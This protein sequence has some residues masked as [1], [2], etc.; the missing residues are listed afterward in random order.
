M[1]MLSAQHLALTGFIIVNILPNHVSMPRSLSEGSKVT[2]DRD[3]KPWGANEKALW[4]TVKWN[5][6][7]QFTDLYH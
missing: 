2:G 6:V 4:L 1:A 5:Q 3:P 7:Q